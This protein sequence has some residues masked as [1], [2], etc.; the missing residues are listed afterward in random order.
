MNAVSLADVVSHCLEQ[1]SLQASPRQ[2]QVL[3]HLLSCRTAAQGA[4]L[5]CCEGCEQRWLRYHS[6]RDRH[7]P[8]CQQQASTQ[9]YERQQA[10]LLPVPY[11]HL[12]FTLPHE[13][14]GLVERH[15]AVLYRLLFQSSWNS[16]NAFGHRRLDG[17]LAMTAVLHTW[18]QQVTRHIHLH[19]LVPAGVLRASGCWQSQQKRYLVPVKALSK[20]F[21]GVMVSALREAAQQGLLSSLSRQE[22]S[23]L[24]ER[25]M[26]KSWVVYSKGALQYRTTLVHYLAR[27]SHRIGLNNSRLLGY[28][29]GRIG[30][31]WRNYRSGRKQVM[32]LQPE[33]LVR[34]FLLHVLPK[35]FM[36]IR[37]YGYLAN[38]VKGKRLPK[39]RAQ[40]VASSDVADTRLEP[41]I[42]PEPC[43]H[44]RC[45]VCGCERV[46]RLGEVLSAALQTVLN[47]S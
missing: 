23:L 31:V 15:A 45:P 29:A 28:R 4:S 7:C 42:E 19:C 8:Q 18:G 21:R 5:Y 14:N 17:Q 44:M 43:G 36:R 1:G 9:W 16:L 13:L 35:G 30:V 24:L 37:H 22:V 39:I 11:F 26:G 41:A 34:R 46:R 12:V 47:S 25:L 38:A 6:C 40:L 27:Y 32:W 33:E 20:R 3:H 10:Q 2:W